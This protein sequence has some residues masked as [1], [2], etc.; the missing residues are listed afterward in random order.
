MYVSITLLPLSLIVPYN[1]GMIR[2]V[3]NFH[4]NVIDHSVICSSLM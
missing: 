1:G 2:I 4:H 3:N